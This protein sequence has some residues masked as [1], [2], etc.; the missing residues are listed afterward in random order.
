MAISPN[1]G[2]VKIPT[3]AVVKILTSSEDIVLTMMMD[4][5]MVTVQVA[6]MGVR[7]NLITLCNLWLKYTGIRYI[8]FSL[9]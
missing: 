2:M 5:I 1:T 8:Y 6:I 7:H 3:L 4:G 9:G